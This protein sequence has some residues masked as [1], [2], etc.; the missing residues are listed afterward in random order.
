MAKHR[1]YRDGKWVWKE[2][3]TTGRG[4]YRGRGTTTTTTKKKKP[5]VAPK[6]IPTIQIEN[7]DK[8]LIAK[9]IPGLDHYCNVKVLRSKD[10]SKINTLFF[11][12][13][14]ADALSFRNVLLN[15]NAELKDYKI[16]LRANIINKKN[17]PLNREYIVKL[18]PMALREIKIGRILDESGTD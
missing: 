2:T 1:V 4:G 10:V 16:K 9:K 17:I 12:E 3:A 14:T 8:S 13:E 15:P 11:Q 18:T 7:I 5:K 6:T